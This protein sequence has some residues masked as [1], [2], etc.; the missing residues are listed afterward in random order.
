MWKTILRR[1]QPIFLVVAL[2]FVAVLLRG[3]WEELRAHTWQ[4]HPGWL[5]ISAV[6]L[7]ASWAM[8]IGIWRHLLALVGGKLAYPPAI[9]IWF[10][11]AIVRYIPGNIWQPLSMTLQ[12]QRRGVRAEATLTSVIL[13]QVII[14]LAVAPI[15]AFYLV[16][17][18]NLG[19]LADMFSSIAP[20]VA[21]G[22][23]VMAILPVVVFL[24]L[25]QLLTGAINW[26]L[27]KAGRDP[28][29][30]E[31]SSGRLL[32]LL[33]ISILNW[34]LWGGS[35][36]ALTFGLNAYTPEQMASLAP[37]LIAS[38]PIAYAIGFLSFVTP[39][40]FGVRE[41]AFYLLLTPL[42]GRRRDHGC[43]AC[44]ARVDHHRRADRGGIEPAACAWAP[45]RVS[46]ISTRCA[47]PGCRR[48]PARDAL[49]GPTQPCPY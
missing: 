48:S 5:F 11:S 30:A 49:G 44:H 12:A 34:L 4:L 8:E 26:L 39:S 36:A 14:V 19:L 22:L 15:T 41:G 28:L 18:G 2:I 27:G 17:T 25:P 1:S 37:H 21:L 9:R 32:G 29:D 13:Y 7:L 31:L 47:Q 6:L 33:L 20:Q 23:A 46:R 40:G 10:L 24:I 43:C 35:F 42:A 16:T 3:Q 45:C 38:Y